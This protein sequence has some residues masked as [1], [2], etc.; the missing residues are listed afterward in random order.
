MITGRL[1]QRRRGF[2]LV[3]LV[4]S[5][6]VFLIIIATAFGILSRYYVIKSFYEQQMD[7]QQNFLYAMERLSSDFRQ[8]EFVSGSVF[9]NPA[10]NAFIDATSTSPDFEKLTF[11][12][13][14]NTQISYYLQENGNGTYTIYRQVDN[15]IPQPVTEEMHQLVKL[16]FIRSGGNVVAVIVGQVTYMGHA[17]KITFSSML[18]SRN[19][20]QSEIEE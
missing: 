8:A 5:I 3:E 1:M 12:G 10:N 6:A 19:S 7:L 9:V 11:W 14:D 17:N 4:V 16:Y 20:P 2:T 15:D 18:Y 13:Q